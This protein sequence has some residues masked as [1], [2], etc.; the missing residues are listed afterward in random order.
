MSATETP[1]AKVRLNQIRVLPGAD[2]VCYS[3][4]C[5]HFDLLELDP[6]TQE[7][8]EYQT[9]SGLTPAAP[10]RSQACLDDPDLFES[11]D[12]S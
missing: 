6:D 10:W 4:E 5:Q 9:N 1:S 7:E 2:R 3:K 12:E 11:S 8:N